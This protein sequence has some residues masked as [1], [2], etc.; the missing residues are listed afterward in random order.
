[1]EINISGKKVFPFIKKITI[2]DEKLFRE[3]GKRFSKRH[4]YPRE[5]HIGYR[6]GKD[7]RL[8]FRHQIFDRVNDI[9][10]E[11]VKDGNKIIRN[12]TEKLSEHRKPKKLSLLTQLKKQ[13]KKLSI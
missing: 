6:I 7:K 4:K 5:E 12:V 9:Y 10:K 8:V 13:N 3:E 11:I 2:I 1:L